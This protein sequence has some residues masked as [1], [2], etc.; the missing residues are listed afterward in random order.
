MRKLI[1]LAL[2]LTALSATAADITIV[3]AG[4]EDITGETPS[5]EFTFGDFPGW[6]F[7]DPSGAKGSGAGPSY[8]VGTLQP[9]IIDEIDENNHQYFHAGAPEGERVA[10]AFNVAASANAEEYGLIQVLSATLQADTRYTL[11]ALVGNIASGTSLDTSSYNLNG[12]PGYRIDL[13]A[14]TTV[15]ASDNNTLADSILEGAFALSTTEY[16]SP[17]FGALIGQQL[18][19]RLVNLNQIDGDF[20]DADREVDF[21]DISLTAVAIPEPASVT[22]LLAGAALAAT[23]RRRPRA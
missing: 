2:S 11:S 1:P 14:G 17:S 13:L 18:A 23:Q 8:Y 7:Y 9:Q 16:T 6:S 10:I 3:N 19:I 21:D 22:L 15:L 5:N 20:P 12:F 4:F